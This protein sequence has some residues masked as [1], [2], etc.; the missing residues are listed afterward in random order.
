VSRKTGFTANTQKVISKAKELINHEQAGIRYSSLVRMISDALPDIPVAGIVNAL[1]Q[2]KRQLPKDYYLPVRG[3]YRNV[4][5]KS[6]ADS[7]ADRP[8]NSPPVS[9]HVVLTKAK[10]LIDAAP[11]GK[12]YSELVRELSAF[13]PQIRPKTIEGA[14]HTLR[15]Q[16]P[17]TYYLPVRG[18]YRN[19]K[20]RDAE[21]L[22]ARTS[23]IRPST[24]IQKTKEEAFYKAFADWLVNELEE[25]TQAIPLGGKRF[26]DKWGTPD[27]IAVREPKRSDLIRPPT[28]IISAELKIDV[29]DLIT[30]FG[31][32]C[33][34]KL[35]SHKSYLVVPR[36]ASDEDKSCLD[37]LT[38]IFGIGLIFFSSDRPSQPQFEIRSRAS[39]EEPDMFY[40]NKYLLLIKDR[41]G[42]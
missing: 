39:R 41:F 33:S 25:A 17:D 3:I 23:P 37:S 11:A 6:E 19:T 15:E 2:F 16:L 28:E 22:A 14:L 24:S 34:Y 5:F 7:L 27:V 13:F 29:M 21:E 18:V 1:T 36:S 12:R 8:A 26:K 4:S 20:F 40:V 42:W 31:Q 9:Y 10:Q 32:C 30:A 35:F 38:R